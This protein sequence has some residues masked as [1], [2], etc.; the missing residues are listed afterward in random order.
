MAAQKKCWTK[1]RRALTLLAVASWETSGTSKKNSTNSKTNMHLWLEL[2]SVQVFTL[3]QKDQ[4][5]RLA[6]TN[7]KQ[8][9]PL[10]DAKKTCKNHP[11]N[12]HTEN[13]KMRMHVGPT[14]HADWKS[15]NTCTEDGSIPVLHAGRWSNNDTAKDFA[16]AREDAFPAPGE[17]SDAALQHRWLI[18]GRRLFF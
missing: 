16:G 17:G 7:L 8:S 5:T 4:T 6:V 14:L 3:S 13:H 11:Q 12:L 10:F 1:R 9:S 2:H 18:A 15:R